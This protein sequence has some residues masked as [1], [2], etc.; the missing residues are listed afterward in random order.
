MLESKNYLINSLEEIDGVA[1]QFLKDFPGLHTFLFNGEMGAGKTTFINALCRSLG[2]ENSSSPTFS[3]VNDYLTP[4]GVQ[5]YHFDLYRLRNLREAYDIGFEEYLESDAI[6]FIEWPE[7]ASE[8]ILPP[9]VEVSIETEKGHRK[10][11]AR[12]ISA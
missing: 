11:E 1:D 8:L 9:F 5:V 12:Y 10:I 4:D 7:K 6:I 2:I 3:I